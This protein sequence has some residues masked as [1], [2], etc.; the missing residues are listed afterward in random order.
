M[1][2]DDRFVVCMRWGRAYAVDYVNVLHSACRAAARKP[3]RFVCLTND[4]HGLD[5]GIEALPVPDIGLTER[6]WTIGGVWPKLAL[7][8]ADLHGLRGRCLF[9]DLDMVV[10]DDLDSFFAQDASYVGIDAGPAW[11][12]PGS[13][14][15][16]QL[17]T[18]MIAFVRGVMAAS[19]RSASI[20]HVA[21]SGST[22]TGLAPTF[23]T[24]SHVAMKVWA[25]TITSSPGPISHAR[26][27]SCRAS[28]PLPTATQCLAWQ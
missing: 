16:P 20:L 26:R 19:I 3:F 1:S 9:I 13:T 22:G 18:G 2:P 8:V 28:S 4:P 15:A 6:E 24:A 25:G 17:G 10:L 12:R 14:A 7:Y 21:S 23:D 11:G 5:A 27:T